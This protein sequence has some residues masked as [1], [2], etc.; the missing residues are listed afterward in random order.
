LCDGTAVYHFIRQTGD[1]RQLDYTRLRDL[2]ARNIRPDWTLF[3]TANDPSNDA[4]VRFL[5]FVRERL[6]WDVEA[7]PFTDAIIPP[8]SVTTVEGNQPRPYIRF[9]AQIAFALGRLAGTFDR[10]LII[11]DSFAISRPVLETARRGTSVTLAYFGSALDP[12]WHR[13]LREAPNQ[14][15][16][17]L[18]DLDPYAD[19]LFGGRTAR[20]A[21]ADTGSP[22]QRRLP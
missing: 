16:I 3:F 11:S 17:S 12:R 18:F 7:V 19:E 14:R 2:I 21:P 10:V 4:Q 8:A 6:G 13:I 22:F 1:G 20:T 15:S 9:D 5:D